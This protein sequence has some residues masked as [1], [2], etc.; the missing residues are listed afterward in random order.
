MKWGAV[1]VRD[2]LWFGLGLYAAV[3]V[4]SLL[5]IV[6]LLRYDKR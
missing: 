2:L 3:M 6:A 1:V 5:A 4:M